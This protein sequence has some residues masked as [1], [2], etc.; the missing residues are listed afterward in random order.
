MPGMDGAEFT[1]QFRAQPLCYDVPVIVVTIY[2]DRSYRYRALEA[3]A[4]DFDPPPLNWSTVYFSE[5]RIKY[6]NEATQT[7]RDSLQA[8]AG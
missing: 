1:R 8:A 3:G 5:R 6:G 4:T 7:R 2:E